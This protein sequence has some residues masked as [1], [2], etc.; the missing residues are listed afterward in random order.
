MF[1]WLGLLSSSAHLFFNSKN[2]LLQPL[3]SPHTLPSIIKE[4]NE[5]HKKFPVWFSSELK[6][7]FLSLCSP[8]AFRCV[9][10][11]NHCKRLTASPDIKAMKP[12]KTTF[13]KAKWKENGFEAQED[14]N[15]QC[16]LPPLWLSVRHSQWLS[17]AFL[18]S[19]LIFF[20]SHL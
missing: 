10:A 12:A 18:A 16:F 5:H 6:L 1:P 15:I 17:F 3:F 4:K 7:Y 9:S 11:Q 14:M 2:Q 20:P 13:F 8:L 19:S